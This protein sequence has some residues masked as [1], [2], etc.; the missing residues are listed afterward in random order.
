M[1]FAKP[2]IFSI[3][4]LHFFEGLQSILGTSGHN[5]LIKRWLCWICC[6]IILLCWSIRYFGFLMFIYLFIAFFNI[7][8][9]VNDIQINI[10]IKLYFHSLQS[11]IVFRLIGW[12][13]SPADPDVIVFRSVKLISS[14]SSNAELSTQ[15]FAMG[16][17][18]F[19]SIFSFLL[20]PKRNNKTEK[21]LPKG[22]SL[23]TKQ[24]S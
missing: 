19:A 9:S 1:Y 13:V 4:I 16:L 18:K 14:M 3:S 6:V 7:L 5:L 8:L 15:C 2:N 21:L 20:Q 12:A 22:W 17:K 23:K 24:S 10:E 11:D